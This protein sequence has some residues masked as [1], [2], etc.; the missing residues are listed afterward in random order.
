MSELK[1]GTC[2]QKDKDEYFW[3]G[4]EAAL[5]IV[6]NSLLNYDSNEL[7]KYSVWDFIEKFKDDLAE[8]TGLYKTDG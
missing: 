5:E 6:E 3:E 1:C 2:G 4:F 7:A 8:E